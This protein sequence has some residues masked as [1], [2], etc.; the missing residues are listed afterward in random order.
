VAAIA[1]VESTSPFSRSFALLSGSSF[2][3]LI[4]ASGLQA[5]LKSSFFDDLNNY[6]Q[7]T[8]TPNDEGFRDHIAGLAMVLP[9]SVVAHAVGTKVSFELDLELARTTNVNLSQA[10]NFPDSGVNTTVGGT[11]QVRVTVK[12]HLTFGVDQATGLSDANAFFF[13]L[14]R[15]DFGVDSDGVALVTITGS[16]GSDPKGT[17]SVDTTLHVGFNPPSATAPFALL[18]DLQASTAADRFSPQNP[19]GELGADL[20]L[21]NALS[22][23]GSVLRFVGTK[24]VDVR[25][26]DAFTATPDTSL[27]LLGEITI[28]DLVTVIGQVT[29]RSAPSTAA[30]GAA[31]LT[32]P[33]KVP[34]TGISVFVGTGWGTATPKGLLLSEGQGGLVLTEGHVAM[35]VQGTVTSYGFS[36]VVLRGSLRVQINNTHKKIDELIPPLIPLSLIGSLP[37][38]A[39]VTFMD[40]SPDIVR[41]TG[42]DRLSIAGDFVL[43]GDF[44]YTAQKNLAGDLEIDV[45]IRD[46]ELFM[47]TGEGTEAAAGVRVSQGVLGLQ[48]VRPADTS[49]PSTIALD[50]FGQASLVGVDK[51]FLN[52]GVHVRY[53]TAGSVSKSIDIPGSTPVVID[54]TAPDQQGTV[55][56]PYICVAGTVLLSVNYFGLVQIGGSVAIERAYITGTGSTTNTRQ[57][58]A[59]LRRILFDTGSSVIVQ[60]DDNYNKLKNNILE[61]VNGAM[62]DGY[63]LNGLT[64]TVNGEISQLGGLQFRNRDRDTHTDDLDARRRDHVV[65]LAAA[66]SADITAS[67]GHTFTVTFNSGELQKGPDTSRQWQNANFSRVLLQESKTTTNPDYIRYRIAATD[68][69][70]FLGDATVQATRTVSGGTNISLPSDAKGLKIEHG[71]LVLQLEIVPATTTPS[72]PDVRRYALDARGAVSFVGFP[73]VTVS[74]TA[75]VRINALGFVPGSTTTLRTLSERWHLCGDPGAVDVDANFTTGGTLENP[76]LSIDAGLKLNLDN[77]VQIAGNVSFTKLTQIDAAAAD[78]RDITSYTQSSTTIALKLDNVVFD[79]GLSAIQSSYD[80][81]RTTSTDPDRADPVAYGLYQR[82]LGNIRSQIAAAESANPGYKVSKVSA[83]VNGSISTFGGA[84]MNRDRETG[85]DDLADNRRDHVVAMATALSRDLGIT[86]EFIG[87]NAPSPAPVADRLAQN[88]NFDEVT[89]TIKKAAPVKTEIQIAGTGIT[90]WVGYATGDFQAPTTTKYGLQLKNGQFGLLLLVDPSAAASAKKKYALHAEGEV[91]LVLAPADQS[92]L[93]LSAG[94]KYIVDINTISG[95]VDRSLEVHDPTTGATLA[96]VKLQYAE[97]LQR[98]CIDATLVVNAFTLNGRFLVER[99]EPDNHASP[100][101]FRTKDGALLARIYPDGSHA[102]VIPA[103]SGFNAASAGVA[104]WVVELRRIADWIGALRGSSFFNTRIP[105]INKTIG[106]VFDIADNFLNDVY[107]QLVWTEIEGLGPVSDAVLNTGVIG[108]NVKFKLLVNG[109]ESPTEVTLLASQTTNNGIVTGSNTPLDNL[110]ADL[111]DAIAAAFP[112]TGSNISPYAGFLRAYVRT[113]TVLDSSGNPTTRRTIVIGS[114]PGKTVNRIRLTADSSSDTSYTILGF[115]DQQEGADHP[116]PNGEEVLLQYIRDHIPGASALRSLTSGPE[117]ATPSGP[118][119]GTDLHF[120]WPKTFSADLSA[121]QDIFGSFGHLSLTGHVDITARI[122][123]STTLGVDLTSV[124]TPRLRN[125]A[126]VPPPSNGRLTDDATFTVILNSSRTAALGAGD[127]Y[128]VHLLRT[129]TASNHSQTN[130]N[131]SVQDLADDLNRAFDAATNSTNSSDALSQHVRAVVVGNNLVLLVKDTELGSIN[132]LEVQADPHNVAVTELGLATGVQARSK[133]KGLFVE[134]LTLTGSI[135]LTASGLGLE[136]T[137]G[138]D[139]GLVRFAAGPGTFNGELRVSVSLADPSSSS[140]RPRVYLSTLLADIERVASY[141]RPALETRAA[142]DLNLPGVTASLLGVNLIDADSNLLRVY[143]PDITDLHVNTQPYNA[144][145]NNKGIFITLPDLGAFQ[146]FNC[147]SI[148]DLL[149]GLTKLGQELEN[150]R[151]FEFLKDPIPGVGISLGEILNI[152]SQIADAVNGILHGDAATLTRLQNDLEAMLHL[153]AGSLTFAVDTVANPK[154]DDTHRIAVFDPQ[155]DNN[156]I[157]FTAVVPSGTF[158]PLRVRFLDDNR[159]APGVDQAEASYDSDRRVLTLYYNAT[160]TRA[161]TV[162]HAVQSLITDAGPRGP[163]VVAEIVADPAAGED[164]SGVISQTAVR[165]QLSFTAE[166]R[167]TVPFYF[168]LKDYVDRLPDSGF[169]AAKALLGALADLVAIEASGNV[170][171]AASARFQLAIGIDV[172]NPCR[173]TPFLYDSGYAGPGTGTGIFLSAAVRGTGLDFKAG[174]LL[175]LRVRNGSITFDADGDPGTAGPNDSARIELQL[176]NTSGAGRHYFRDPLLSLSNFDLTLNAGFSVILPVFGLSLIPLGSVA[177][178]NHDGFSDNSLAMIVPSLGDLLFHGTTSGIRFTAPDIASLFNSLDVCAIIQTTPVLL[179]GLDELLG[180]I[181]SG[182]RNQVLNTNLPLVGDKLSAAANFISDF[183]TGLLGSIRAKLAEAGSPIDLVKEAIFSVLGPSGLNLLVKVDSTGQLLDSSDHVIEPVG[184]AY[185][186]RTVPITD[187]HDIQINCNGNNLDFKIRL[188]K[189]ADL[190]DTSANPIAFNIGVPGFGLSVDGNVRVSLGFDLKLYFGVNLNQG[191]YYQADYISPTGVRTP[192]ADEL[193]VF[194]KVTIPGLHA[195]GQLFFLQ[196]DVSDESDGHDAEGHPRD[197]SLLEGYFVV[198]IKDPVGNDGKLTASDLQR[199]G[200]SLSD[201][202]E[203]KLGVQ[204]GIH[205]DLAV[206]FGGNTQFPRLLAEFDLTWKW[207]LGHDAGIP[208]IG[209]NHIQLDVGTFIGQ[210]LAPILQEIKKVTGPLQPVVDAITAPIPILS[211]L[212]GRPFNML[213]L[214]ELFGYLTPSSRKFIEAIATII[215]VANNTPVVGDTIL[216]PLGNIA[217]T[218]DT[219]GNVSSA[220]K[221]G[222]GSSANQSPS[223]RVSDSSPGGIAGFF[224]K[225]EKIGIKFP[226]LDISAVAQLFA[227]KPVS[228]IEYHMPVLELKAAFSQTINI[229]GP[230]AVFFGGE[231]GVKVDLTFGYDTYG[232][233]KFFASSDKDP[234][235]IFDGFYIKDVDDKGVDVPEITFKGGLFVGAG[236]SIG[237]A[238]LG[239]KGGIF[240]EI[241]L[242]LNDPDGDGRVRVSEIIANAKKDVRCIFDIS[243]EVYAE[244]SIFLKIKLFFTINLEWTFARISILKFEI[245]CPTPV[246][247]HF[248]DGPNLGTNPFDG[249]GGSGRLVLNMGTY[250]SLRGVDDTTDGDETFVVKH[251]D[252]SPTDTNGETVDIEFGGIKQT[253]HGVKA[254]LADGGKGNDTIDLRDVW[255]P[256]GAPASED[257]KGNATDGVVGGPGSDVIYASKGGGKFSGDGGKESAGGDGDD[258]I[259]APD[260]VVVSYEFHGN[261]G[262][263]TLTGGGGA[264]TIHGDGGDDTIK[265]LAGN[266]QLFGDDGVDLVQGDEGDDTIEGGSGRDHLLGNDGNDSILGGNGDDLIEGGLGN[267]HL[268]GNDGGDTI[269]GGEGDDVI[270]GDNG[271]I[272]ADGT[273]PGGLPTINVTGIDGAGNDILVG[274]GGADVIFGCDGND[275]IFGGARLDAGSLTPVALDGVDFI[276]GG[277][278]DDHLFADDAGGAGTSTFPGAAIAGTVWLDYI[279][280]SIRDARESGIAGVV[281]E[282]HNTAD[283]S[284]VATTRSDAGGNYQFQ[285]LRAGNYTV[286]FQVPALLNPDGTPA[287][288]TLVFVTQDQGADDSVD[289]DAATGTGRT[290]SVT[291]AEGASA[292]HVD[293]GFASTALQINIDNPSVREGNS[294]FSDLVFTVTLSQPASEVVSVCYKTLDGTAVEDADYLGADWTLVFNPGE[295]TKTI[296]IKVRGDTIDEGLSETLG[297]EICDVTR[298][299]SRDNIVLTR[300]QATGTIID[301]DAPPVVSISDGVQIGSLDGGVIKVHESDPIRFTVTL[302]NPSAVR[303]YVDWRTAQV[304]GSDGALLPNSA[305]QDTDYVN[306]AGQLTFEPGET[307]KTLDVVSKPDLL[308]EYDEQF[309][310]G[311]SMP[312]TTPA[313]HATLGDAEGI[314]HIADDDATPYLRFIPSSVSVIEGQSGLVPVTLTVQLYDPLTNLPTTSGR[315]VTVSWSTTDGTATLTGTATT[316]PDAQYGF[317]TLRFTPGQSSQQI[318]VQVYGDQLTEPDEYFYVNLL[319]AEN[320]ILDPT[321]RT[322]NHATVNIL[323]DEIPDAGPWYVGF[324]QSLYT[325]KEGD[326]IDVTIDRPLGSSEPDAVLWISFA[327]ATRGTAPGGNADYEA[328]F[329]FAGPRQRMAI[330]FADGETEKTFHI[331]TYTD[332]KYEGDEVIVLSLANPTGGPVRAPNGQATVVIKDLQPAPVFYVDDAVANEADGTV[333]I[334]I[335]ATLPDDVTLGAGLVVSVRWRTLDGTAKAGFPELDYTSEDHPA[336]ALDTE[337]VRFTAADFGGPDANSAPQ[338]ARRTVHVAINSGDT[339]A[340]PDET[341]LVDLSEPSNATIGRSRATVTIHDDDLVPVTGYVFQDLNGNGRYDSDVDTR[342]GGVAVKIT[343]ADGTITTTNTLSGGDWHASVVTGATTVEVTGIDAVLVGAQCSTHNNPLHAQVDYQTSAV[344]DIGFNVRATPGPATG[345]TG[346]ALVY[347]DDTVYGGPGNDEIDGGGGNDWLV[348]GHWL[349]PGCACSGRPYDAQIIRVTGSG[350]RVTRT[351]VNPDTLAA[352]GAITGRVWSDFRSPITVSTNGNGLQDAGE[353]GVAGVQVNLFDEDWVFVGTTYTDTNGGYRFDNLA[354]CGYVVQ[355]TLP[356][357]TRFTLNTFGGPTDRDSNADSATGLT[358]SLPVA[359]GATASH[360]DAGLLPITA[361]AGG[362]WNVS[363]GSPVYSVRQSDAQALIRILHA[364]G[365]PDGDADFFTDGGTAVPGS[366]YDPTKA[367]LSFADDQLLTTLS[368]LLHNPGPK[369]APRTVQL[370]LRNP[371]G[372][373]VRGAVP[374]AVLLIFDDACLDNDVIS[375][376]DGNDILLGDY[377]LFRVAGD[378][379]PT[380]VELGGMGNDTLYGDTGRDEIHG[381][382]GNDRIDGGRGDDL[383][384]GGSEN[385]TYVFNGDPDGGGLTSAAFD[386]DT[387][388]EPAAPLGGIDLIDLSRTAAF[389]IV[390]NLS[391]ATEQTVTPALHLTLP[392]GLIEGV[393]GGLRDDTLLGSDAND[394]LDGGAGNDILEGGRGDDV[395]VGGS[396]SDTYRFAADTNLGADEIREYATPATDADRDLIDF[397][398]TLTTGARLDLGLTTQQSVNA[399]LRLTLSDSQGIENLYGTAQGDVLAGNA[400]DNVIWGQAGSDALD[401]GPSGYDVLKE[402][403][404]GNWQLA[405]GTLTLVGAGEIDT[406][407][408]GSFDE[409]SLTGNDDAN[410]LDASTFNGLVR[411]D[412]RGGNDVLKGGSG[413]NYLTGGRGSDTIVGGT[414]TDI[415]TEQDDGDYV[416]SPGSLV[417]TDAVTHAVE[418]DT[419]SGIDQVHLTGGI[420]NNQLDASA[421]SGPVT[422][423]GLAGDDHL[424]GGSGDD[425]LI[426]GTGDDTLAGGAGNDRYVFNGDVAEGQDTVLEVAGQ[427]DDVLD[428]SSTTSIGIRFNLSLSAAQAYATP[429]DPSLPPGAPVVVPTLRIL[430]PFVENLIGTDQADILGGNALANRIEGRGG[431]DLLTGG[432]GDDVLDGGDGVDRVAE[433]TDGNAT[434]VSTPVPAGSATLSFSGIVGSDLHASGEVDTLLAVEA[435]T[436]TGGAGNNTLDASTFNGPVILIGGD[437]DDILRGGPGNDVLRGGAGDDNMSGGDGN[438]VY[439]FNADTDFGNDQLLEDPHY[440][441]VGGVPYNTSVDYLDFSETQNTGVVVNLG[442]TVVQTVTSRLTIWLRS[443]GGGVPPFDGVIGGAKNDVLYGNDLANALVGGRGDDRLVDAGTGP[444]ASI[445]YL[446]GEEGDD[447][448][449]FHDVATFHHVWVIESV[450]TGGTDTVDF[451]ALSGAVNIDLSKGVPQAVASGGNLILEFPGCHTVENVLGTAFSDTI[452]GNSTN[453]KLVGGGGSDTLSGARGDDVLEGGPGNDQLAG[454]WGDDRYVYSGLVALGADRITELAGQGTDVIDL[455]GLPGTSTTL[456]L[457]LA[458]VPQTLRVGSSVTLAVGGT[459]D[460]V[461]YPATPVPPVAPAPASDLLAAALDAGFR[462]PYLA[463]FTP[464]PLPSLAPPGVMMEEPPLDSALS[465][466]RTFAWSATLARPALGLLAGL[467][468]A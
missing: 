175:G 185:L 45:G 14:S 256:A 60:G 301:D 163:P 326:G 260:G 380:V 306:A 369:G 55:A 195:R 229:W 461:A 227:G 335:Q 270:V 431:N 170:S 350:G 403:R 247:A 379:T 101:D 66:L 287:S 234:L 150:V 302:S 54:F 9:G 453:N 317:G 373:P 206:S 40:P 46:L 31:T 374:V 367:V 123:L 429:I 98:V 348:G 120:T 248:S 104:D 366:E 32:N 8:T 266:D 97:E 420:H 42:S 349:G 445:E 199:P 157:R 294:G 82:L 88:A 70:V 36:D 180:K 93:H 152:G 329:S 57:E 399:N 384:I 116:Q 417:F 196:L 207:E 190:V 299:L 173:P 282:L 261:G 241:R 370:F 337:S 191:F 15:L 262:N 102:A 12:M 135:T 71:S 258:T 304:V 422:L 78:T 182:L 216:I 83:V 237:F 109:A 393:I 389:S 465:P 226:I 352:L 310:V 68:V 311:L 372:G 439:Q 284:L 298:G 53:N 4:T 346:T 43:N 313:S 51:L 415:L 171:I 275:W 404:A 85:N 10:A 231:I 137:L 303:I 100:L 288:A 468:R 95:G 320:G 179:D 255:S 401:G 167:Q 395:L 91:D 5:Q 361:T 424:S 398:A 413:T 239:V 383:L 435:V 407:V 1:N 197:S 81:S 332:N 392:G 47:G 240:A 155:G 263:D 219:R 427:G 405:T 187:F 360:I 183:R 140:G 105:L 434:L 113:A 459:V 217:I 328:N 277:A 290:S 268:V 280:N 377:G 363:F 451:R 50:A 455:T 387:I 338:V 397:S 62:A 56:R 318:T 38:A 64:A 250:A 271:T 447:T 283:D 322:G 149:S 79:T 189:V 200:L 169:G 23:G 16:T 454:G 345:S 253:F 153:P 125:A 112:A 145:T 164:G 127:R 378:G 444:T 139:S 428:F 143:I 293:A 2:G 141:I 396:G 92:L 408:A 246:L 449:E 209:I 244:L 324:G 309:A 165:L 359:A 136:A 289:S 192:V 215:D 440:I 456:N 411:L 450:G 464:P 315:Y 336:S 65:A 21:P 347:N 210:F 357:S 259:I 438:D 35:D 365:T 33:T 7:N 340:E 272:G 73:E 381:E 391:L 341:F 362:P 452:R 30:P 25:A 198:D 89:F 312:Y 458:L 41:I 94:G 307:A 342:L 132:S 251:V 462:A 76:F 144:T 265:G 382:G 418:T 138:G 87:G 103:Y 106:E 430:Q 126:L 218:Q 159:Y 235:V 386:H 339:T 334:T 319:N 355:F 400:R 202:V 414:G 448:Y 158:A 351:Y 353:L 419:L 466:P 457:K 375:G 156:G 425:V 205:L 300:T 194:F 75:R 279:L 108:S 432:G 34:L 174:G 142:V 107:S 124:E 29:L 178:N 147:L 26:S 295:T 292:A 364:A 356:D 63:T 133:V 80:P 436:L 193:R 130:D 110:A 323:N 254:I 233:Q 314:G 176:K 28:A 232:L 168:R 331:Q 376:R 99:F 3:S 238:E 129:Q 69:L 6:L 212:V 463:S 201:V 281:V 333:A 296:T 423:E 151:G 27:S 221:A 264:D 203:F 442:S 406:F 409:I 48:L 131:A 308:D 13:N 243:G 134:G 184:D 19:A 286:R 460:Q 276:D 446:S 368:I 18:A 297:L 208:V 166:Y 160:Y 61:I 344:A 252:G 228:I 285:G 236:L 162:V 44:S 410:V 172:S 385:D 305:I 245:T 388:Q 22:L 223:E 267:D 128:T 17:L 188:M 269:Y 58:A 225:L 121:D 443:S 154:L 20:P 220:P 161:S 24:A 204:A 86:V 325:V 278:G 114:V 433:S 67:L 181:E 146:Q 257:G 118:L 371:T 412:G 291:L 119:Q 242:N 426:G 222:G 211:D 467:T 214:A 358:A 390:I 11:A 321:D 52:G 330:N 402:L 74:G 441:L 224:K 177:D 96:T 77:W 186:S 354:A 117:L 416:L 273:T 316:P 437:G 37:P 343:S 39:R 213:D 148:V 421:W 49:K 122:D 72:A 249:T 274:E 84:F 111:S 230:I 59:S 115:N 327:T 90:G 394:Y